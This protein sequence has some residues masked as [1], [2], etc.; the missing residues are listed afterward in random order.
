MKTLLLDIGNV[1]MGF[2]F[3]RARPRFAE[4][5][6][7]LG[8]PIELLARLKYD[9][10]IGNIDGDAF[11]AAGMKTLGFQKSAEDFRRIWEE[12]F[13]PIDAMWEFVL[14]VRATHRLLLLSNT[15][16]IHKDCLFRDYPN[17]GHFSGGIYSYSSHYLKPDPLIFRQAIEEFSLDPEETIYVDDLEDNVRVASGIGFTAV[18]YDLAAHGA[19]M[20]EVRALGLELPEG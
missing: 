14:R 19:F 13:T 7:A 15:S 16:D 12:I 3:G 18:R 20:A 2:D 17:F 6:T 4:A 8:D 10:E 5:S 9:L 1:L 11:V